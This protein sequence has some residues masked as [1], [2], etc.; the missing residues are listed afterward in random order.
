[1]IL[2]QIEQKTLFDTLIFEESG[3]GQWDSDSANERAACTVIPVYRCPSMRVPEHVDDNPSGSLV[4]GR[5]PISYRACSGSN[6]WSDDAT[7]IPLDEPPG[8]LALDS[9]ALNAV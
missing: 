1:M 8:A 9:V 2:P 5:V 6:G 4:D 7:T 3:P